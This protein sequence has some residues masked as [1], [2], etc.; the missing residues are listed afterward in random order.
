MKK[1]CRSIAV[2]MLTVLCLT[3]CA[4]DTNP[5]GLNECENGHHDLKQVGYTAPTCQTIGA[6]VYTCTRCG[7]TETE[8]LFPINHNF[9]VK[10][11]TPSTCTE[12]GSQLLE[13][14]MCHT[15][16]T[17][18]L[19]LTEHD[20]VQQSTV[21]STCLQFGKTIEKCSNCGDEKTNFNNIILNHVFDST[22]FCIE[23]GISKYYFDTDLHIGWFAPLGRITIDLT[24]LFNNENTNTAEHWAMHTV[25]IT[26]TCYDSIDD[27]HPTT[28]E[29]NS[30][31]NVDNCFCSFENENSETPLH[32]LIRIGNLINNLKKYTIR[33]DC[34]GFE[35]ISQTFVYS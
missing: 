6:R 21:P 8:T 5:M 35:T 17:E 13:C 18:I 2:L 27:V 7:Y 25:Y 14:S 1:L 11:T 15:P 9:E 24:P 32:C 19:P 28:F 29:Y 16:K 10:S 26:L 20:Y 30:K 3:L 33:I 31:T 22:G 12:K 34:D 4:C 23:C